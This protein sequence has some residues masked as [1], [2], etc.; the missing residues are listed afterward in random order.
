MCLPVDDPVQSPRHTIADVSYVVSAQSHRLGTAVA[1]ANFGLPPVYGPYSYLDHLDVVVGAP[2][3]SSSTGTGRVRWIQVNDSTGGFSHPSAHPATEAFP[4][5]TGADAFGASLLATDVF[6]YYQVY[7]HTTY[8][9]TSV[10][11]V[12]SGQETLIGAPASEG[13]QG[14]VFV[15]QTEIRNSDIPAAAD[16][17]VWTWARTQTISSPVAGPVRFGAAIAAP[18]TQPGTLSPWVAIGAPDGNAVYVYQNS[19][20]LPTTLNL[21]QTITPATLNPPITTLSKFG[22]SL[23][24]DDMNRDGIVDLIIGSPGGTHGSVLVIAG[25]A[26]GPLDPANCAIIHSP[27][28]ASASFGA[29]LASGDLYRTGAGGAG[30]RGMAAGA[31][32]AI[33]GGAVCIGNVDPADFTIPPLTCLDNPLPASSG[34]QFGAAVAIGNFSPYDAFLDPDSSDAKIAELAVGAPGAD[35][36]AWV[37]AG[38]GFTPVDGP[39]ASTG[40]VVFF[41]SMVDT[42][43]VLLDD[44]AEVTSDQRPFGERILRPSFPGASGFGASLAVVDAQ[45]TGR[46]DL[47]VGAP[48]RPHSGLPGGAV[49]LM[50]SRPVNGLDGNLGGYFTAVDGAGMA[51]DF[52]FVAGTRLFIASDPQ[53]PANKF[54]LEWRR[55]VGSPPVSEVCEILNQGVSLEM[56]LQN[57]FSYLL[58]TG[59]VTLQFVIDIDGNIIAEAD[60]VT[61]AAIRLTVTL[62]DADFGD[63]DPANDTFILDIDNLEHK[64]PLGWNALPPDCQPVGNPFVFTRVAEFEG[65]CE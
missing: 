61:G 33:G 63:T 42:G 58:G 40:A 10:K 17:S 5:S 4:P 3:G 52:T 57:A 39:E 32:D 59:P 50:N 31:P 22:A 43:P 26:T 53:T 28:S 1:A 45:G 38:D 51:K 44:P 36:V 49:Q 47:L 35:D 14:R 30:P 25:S 6:P 27:V 41:R 64:G 48:D 20:L 23:L 21:V 19:P 8:P 2:G 54:L 13:G 9:K 37:P 16:R 7:D 12:R 24:A 65:T 34:A 18:P 60:A 62:S 29:S 56:Y 15:F 11:V 55:N 46:P